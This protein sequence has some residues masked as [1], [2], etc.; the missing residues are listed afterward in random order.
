MGAV[1]AIVGGF[2]LLVLAVAVF[3]GGDEE[4]DSATDTPAAPASAPAAAEEPIEE[5]G[6]GISAAEQAWLEQMGEQIRYVGEALGTLGEIT[7]DPQQQTLLLLGDQDTT[8]KAAVQV[9]VMQ[10]CATLVEDVGPVPT[11]R[12]R[13]I[14]R[15]VMNA[16]RHYKAAGDKFAEGIDTTDPD[17]IV[18]AA[19]DMQKGSVFIQRATTRLAELSG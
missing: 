16:C 2:I 11:P 3:G 15:P 4:T 14:R 12:L 17:L 18:A 9:A 5:E 7:T 13:N 19:A 1:K 10:Q 6:A 8:I